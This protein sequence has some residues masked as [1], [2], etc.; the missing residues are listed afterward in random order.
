M[1]HDEAS[2]AAL[3]PI[4]YDQLKAL[5][6]SLLKGQRAHTLQPTALVHET[7]VKLADQQKLWAGRE[8]FMATAAIAMRQ[9]LVDHARRKNAVKR[10]GL[11]GWRI[12]ISQLEAQRQSAELDVE[13]L[14]RLLSEL[15]RVDPR[16]TRIAEM[17]LFG[18]MEH[19]EIAVVLDISRATVAND[20]RFARA[21]LA[22]RMR[23]WT[24][25]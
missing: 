11:S 22:G 4:V 12:T 10:G 15:S 6:G 5:A 14:D 8:H 20:W 1:P 16:A 21:W 3:V 13:D 24:H 19:A 2:F 9:V 17:R 25:E 23:G 7:F 18:G